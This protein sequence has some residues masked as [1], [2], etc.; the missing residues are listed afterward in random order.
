M[1]FFFCR[2][3]PATK[4]YSK[5]SLRI[6]FNPKKYRFEIRPSL[7]FQNSKVEKY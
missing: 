1:T 7:V 4:V 5:G 2:I 6:H 3:M